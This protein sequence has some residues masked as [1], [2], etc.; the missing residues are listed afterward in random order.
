[1]LW[2]G[3]SEG[4]GGEIHPLQNNAESPTEQFELN[5]EDY[6]AAEEQGTVVAIVHSH[7]GDGATTQPSELDML[8][9]DATELP[10]YCIVAGGRHS[11][12]HASRRPSLTGRQFV[13]GYADCWSLIMDYFRIEHGIE[14]P[15]Y[16]VDRHWWEQGENLYM[17]N[18]QEC[19]FREYDGPAQPVTWLSC[20]YSPPSRTMRVFCWKATCCCTMYGQLSQRIPYGGYYRDRTIK[21]L[22]YKDLM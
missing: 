10:D 3:Y 9:C 20:R 11:H 16:S 8:M 14:L 17:D 4:A 19:G 12:R 22:R 7:P 21:I 13:L 5:P 2:R 1:M 6:A 18:W 15:N